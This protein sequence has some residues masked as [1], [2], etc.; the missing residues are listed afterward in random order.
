MPTAVLD[1]PRLVARPKPPT[2][3]ARMFAAAGGQVVAVEHPE[4]YAVL[5][6]G[7]EVGRCLTESEALY[8]MCREAARR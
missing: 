1:R 8:L 6:D 2:V 5:R 7:Q 3:V 4:G